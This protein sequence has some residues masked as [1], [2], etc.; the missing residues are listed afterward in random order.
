MDWFYMFGFEFGFK[1]DLCLSFE[2]LIWFTKVRKKNE[3]ASILIFFS[4]LCT[5]PN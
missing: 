1:F 4:Y 5:Q 3:K 2:L